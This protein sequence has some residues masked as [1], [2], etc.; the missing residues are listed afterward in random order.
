MELL[1][2]YTSMTIYLSSVLQA[3]YIS[4]ICLKES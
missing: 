2:N 3:K 4:E 1:T